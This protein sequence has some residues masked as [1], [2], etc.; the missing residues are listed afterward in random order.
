MKVS[1]IIPVYNVEAYVGECLESVRRQTLR[2]LEIIC[3]DDCSQDG[4]GQVLRQAAAEDPRIR[5]YRNEKNAGLASA[6]NR[7]LSLAG[8]EYVYFLDADDLIVPDALEKLCER[9]DRNRLD[10][11][12]FCASFI[13]ENPGLE[14]RFHRNPAVF[15]SEYPDTLTGREL[16]IR[17]MQVWDWMPSQPR[18]FYRRSFL[19]EYGIRFPDGALHEDE[20]FAFDVLMAARR[21]Q[22]RP[23]R[24]F[25]RRFRESS[26][27][28]GGVTMKNVDGCIRILQHIAAARSLY[29]EDEALL[30]AVDFYRKKIA[31]NCRGKFKEACGKAVPAEGEFSVTGE[32][33]A[34]SVLI[35]V[36]NVAPYLRECLESILGQSMRNLEV[37]CVDD[38]SSDDSPAILQAYRQM[39]PRVRVI[40]CGEN[41]GQAAARNLAVAHARGKMIY[42]AD[43]D[44]WLMDDA[45]ET[46]CTYMEQD[47]LDVIGFENRQFAQEERFAAQ[48]A[49]VLFS[50]E[51][52]QGLYFDGEA[53]IT[54]VEKDT[55]SPSV[56]TYMLRRDFLLRS[57][58]A[59]REGILHEDI[60][61]I[62]EMLTMADR[63][64]LLHR[65]FYARRFRAHSTVTA[66]FDRRH[67]LGYLK[68]WQAARENLPR[69]KARFGE[70]EAFW[71]AYR[72]WG[73]DVS[74]R[75]QMLYETGQ[76]EIYAAQTEEEFISEALLDLLCQLTPGSALARDVLG[77]E[78]LGELETYPALYICGSGQYAN[79]MLDVIGTLPVE[80]RGVLEEGGTAGG[81]KTMRGFRVL[82]PLTEG[83]RELP[84]VMAVSHYRQKKYDELLK[85]AGFAHII[86]P[87]W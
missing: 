76:E 53:F 86:I 39:D 71:H 62:F 51:K 78:L 77:D 28:T 69:L 81:R 56:P 82:D 10:A 42:M 84:V 49:S 15:K 55:L 54:C 34:V 65:P 35:P 80:I 8:G 9:A 37:I 16:Y 48:A 1:V 85:R 33:P 61:F 23:E 17:W 22:A 87:D 21:I 27:M 2:D 75:I 44:D 47:D 79:R 68:S 43:A 67:A 4:S 29:L 5:I 25:I 26:I 57:G 41:K 50:Y 64:R 6:R 11:I 7:G 72:K 18:Y 59:F 83:D 36:Y 14:E 63:V 19:E 20:S 73:R 38:G 12:V 74:G 45:L 24:W 66:G 70:S 3:I 32:P 31:E 52:T 30:G 40:T 60:G 46:L 58:L 13:Y